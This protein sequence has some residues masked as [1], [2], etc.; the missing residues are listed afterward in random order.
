MT[1]GRIL[2]PV[3]VTAVSLQWDETRKFTAGCFTQ[4]SVFFRALRSL[5]DSGKERWFIR[6]G[7]DL[8]VC[9]IAPHEWKRGPACEKAWRR[10]TVVAGLFWRISEE[11]V[12]KYIKISH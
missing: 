7:M 6:V 10:H 5:C 12:F 1:V 8:R 11:V 2:G 4:G 3:S 9:L